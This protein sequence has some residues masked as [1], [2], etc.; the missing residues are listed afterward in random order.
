MLHGAVAGRNSQLSF[1]FPTT[2][3]HNTMA[4]VART[5]PAAAAVT[6]LTLLLIVGKEARRADAYTVLFLPLDERFTTRFAGLNLGRVTPFD[7]ITPPMGI[8]SDIRTPAP[9]PALDAW[10]EAALPTADAAVISLE[11]YVYGGLIAS[12]ISN[13]T[14]EFVAARL[15]RLVSLLAANSHVRVHLATVVMRIPSYS[16]SPPIEDPWCVPTG[17]GAARCRAIHMRT[18]APHGAHGAGTGAAM[19]RSCSS[20]ATTWTRIT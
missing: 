6:M 19:A 18:P 16:Y 10:M 13:D 1:L 7:V 9:L 17:T 11:L 4:P 5:L 8:I 15:N 2:Q 12:R 3:R 20:T 14:T